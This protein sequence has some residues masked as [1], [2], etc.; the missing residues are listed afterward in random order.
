MNKVMIVGLDG[1]TF[2]IIRPL[3]ARGRLP[4][5][6]HMIENGASGV[7]QSTIPP[8][9][10]AAWTS[11]FSGKN[12]GKHGIYDFQALDFADYSFSTVRTDLHREKTL[13]QLLGEAGLRSIVWDVPFTYPPRPL[14]GWML[15]GY[16]TPR[17]KGTV[18][19]SPADLAELVPADLRAE[20][21]VAQPSVRFDRS[22]QFID[23]W[24]G[25]MAGRARLLDWLVRQQD[26]D[27]FSVVFS[28]TDSMAHVFWTYVDPNHPNYLKPEAG[29]YRA[30]FFDAYENCDRILGNLIEAAGSGTTTLVIS[31]HGFGSVRPRQ[32]IYQRLMRGGYLQLKAGGGAATGARLARIAADIY[33]RF[34]FLREWVKGL[35]HSSRIALMQSLD[36]A[37]VIPSAERIDFSRS[38]IIP[39]NFGLRMWVNDAARFPTG[40][41]EPDLIGQVMEALEAHLLAD[42]DPIN[43]Q[44]IVAAVHRGRDLYHGEFAFQGPDLVIEYA[45]HFDF[46]A[47]PLGNNPYTEGGHTVEGIFIAHGES[48]RPAAL[49]SASLADLAPTVLHL[50]G[51]PVPPDMDGRALESALAETFLKSN[52]VRIGDQPAQMEAGAAEEGYSAE[53]EAELL[54]QLRRLGYV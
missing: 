50:L 34:P 43:G 4:N 49:D 2:D 33:L 9:T 28:I 53:E 24:R 37:G 30:A 5:L 41:V 18:F 48:I 13:W 14:A 26:W 27:L 31:D 45:N 17:V 3:I 1:A 11:F 39:T 52:P 15:T 47:E 54:E 6:A 32:Y 40:A 20:I 7:L 46:E 42:R 36:R 51:Q 44:P 16:G 35:G 23:E 25:I 10:P 22:S 21:R 8:V 12:P 38:K 29:Q 19:T